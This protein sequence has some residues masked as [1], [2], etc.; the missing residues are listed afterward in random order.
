MNTNGSSGGVAADTTA[1]D[2]RDGSRST[3]G[4]TVASIEG[5]DLVALVV[6]CATFAGAITGAATTAHGQLATAES[7]P[8]GDV[9]AAF[10]D[11][12]G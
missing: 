7:E 5:S 9:S 2:L 1:R 12:G 8:D 3:S 4:T 10:P 11:A 6:C